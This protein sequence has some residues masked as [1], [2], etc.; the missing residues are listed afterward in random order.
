MNHLN[1]YREYKKPKSNFSK[2]HDIT[3]LELRDLCIK[4]RLNPNDIKYLGS[5]VFGNAYKVGDKVLKITKHKDEAKS[6]YDL[7]KNNIK[8]PGI[9]NYYSVNMFKHKREYLYVIVMD[10]VQSLDN[11]IKNKFDSYKYNLHKFLNFIIDIIWEKWD[12]LKL[13]E[14]FVKLVA[15]EYDTENKNIIYFMEKIWDL[16]INLQPYLPHCPDLHTGNIGVKNNKFIYYDYARC[17]Y[18]RK[19][20]DPSIL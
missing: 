3:K 16:F 9:V 7:I 10:Y 1:E 18:I 15:K 4:L 14:Y 19:Y 2:L 13:Y 20:S 12:K 5:G 17:E 11:F 6:V 8:I